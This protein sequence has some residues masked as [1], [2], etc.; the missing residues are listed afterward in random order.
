MPALILLHRITSEE[1]PNPNETLEEKARETGDFVLC[2]LN[3]K[4]LQ[5]KLTLVP[6]LGLS[7]G[8]PVV[9]SY[10]HLSPSLLWPHPLF[11][12]Y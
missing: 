4:R 6:T 1:L 3:L 11:C 10:T 2:L 8:R 5:L 7:V 12:N 9:L